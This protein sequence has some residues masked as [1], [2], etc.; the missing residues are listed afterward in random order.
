[1]VNPDGRVDLGRMGQGYPGTM[2]FGTNRGPLT[3]CVVAE[4]QRFRIFQRH[5]WPPRPMAALAPGATCMQPTCTLLP[6]LQFSL[7]RWRLEACY[8]G[9]RQRSRGQAPLW[10]FP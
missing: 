10:F 7:P 3:V 6:L 1:M 8:L 4:A 9:N 5:Y 2:A